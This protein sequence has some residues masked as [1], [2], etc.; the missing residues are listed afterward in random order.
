M[1]PTHRVYLEVGTKRVFAGALRWP[2]W[3]RS[4]RDEEAALEALLAY[5]QRY[6]DALGRAAKG[7]HPPKRASELRVV[8]RLKGDATTDFGAPSATPAFDRR[9]LGRA[10]AKSLT[11]LLQASWAAFDRTAKAAAGATLRKGPRG[12]GRDLDAIVRHV[13]EAD[14][15]YLAKLGARYRRP[16]DSADAAD[17]EA[18]ASDARAAAADLLAALARGKPPPR[19]PRSGSLWTPRYYVRRSAWHAMDHAWEIGDRARAMEVAH[20]L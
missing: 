8:E 12:G 9:S 10:G 20:D 18:E 14:R 6:V 13:L 19:T 2:G 7:F 16:G 17:V 3:C 11:T 5:G 15:A 4:G 1:P